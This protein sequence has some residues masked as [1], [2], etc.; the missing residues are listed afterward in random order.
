MTSLTNAQTYLA[1]QKHRLKYLEGNPLD[2]ADLKRALVE[3]SKC[4]ILLADK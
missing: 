3:A 2:N 4:I 1:L